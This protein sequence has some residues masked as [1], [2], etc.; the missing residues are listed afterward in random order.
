[1]NDIIGTHFEII[2]G[3]S[4]DVDTKPIFNAIHEDYEDSDLDNFFDF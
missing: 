3:C 4:H 2:I 1:M